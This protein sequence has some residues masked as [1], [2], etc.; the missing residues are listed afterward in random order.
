MR[1]AVCRGFPKKVNVSR[2]ATSGVGEVNGGSISRV[3]Y[4]LTQYLISQRKDEFGNRPLFKAVDL[5][6]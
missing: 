3:T 1:T 4:G 5:L 6:D 2:T